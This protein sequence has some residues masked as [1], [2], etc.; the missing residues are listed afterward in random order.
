MLFWKLLAC[1]LI[2]GPGLSEGMILLEIEGHSFRTEVADEPAERQHGLMYRTELDQ[3]SGMV[4]VYPDEA[5]RGFWMDKTRIPLSI[6][7]IDKAGTIIQISDLIPF[8]RTTVPSIAPAMY[9]LEVNRGRFDALGITKGAI[10]KGLPGPS[11]Q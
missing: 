1:G 2:G 6:A 4:F 8:D 5:P 3:D 7:Y 9:A 11:K 10:V